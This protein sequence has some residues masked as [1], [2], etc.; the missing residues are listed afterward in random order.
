MMKNLI[1]ILMELD[2]SIDWENEDSLI[3]NRILDSFSMITLI[4]DLE[5]GFDIEIDAAEIVPENFNSVDAMWKMIKR[6]QEN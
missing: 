2:D 6:L 5:D 4:S 3:D 1:D